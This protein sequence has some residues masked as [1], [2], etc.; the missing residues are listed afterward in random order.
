MT[1]VAESTLAVADWMRSRGF[2][3][4]EYQQRTW[5]ASLAGGSG[6]VHAPTGMGKTYAVWLGP[7]EQAIRDGELRAAGSQDAS[8][9]HASP[10]TDKPAPIRALWITPLRALAS[11]TRDNLARPVDDLG[12]N[13]S[14]E[15][16]TGDT[17]S[18][19]KARQRRR[20]PS[21]LVTTPESLTILLSYPDAHDKLK[22][23]RTVIVD[24]WHELLGTKRGTQT[25]LALAR[26]RRLVPGLRT[27]GLSATL[28]NLETARR[29]LVGAAPDRAD[30]HGPPS[31]VMIEGPPDKP[32]EL[33]VLLP[34]DIERFPWAGH[35]GTKLLPQVVEKIRAANSTLVFTNTRAQCEIWF[36]QINTFAPDLVGKVA[37]HHGSLDG[38]L[39]RKAEAMIRG[40]ELK[41]VVCTSS[42]DLGVD[43]AP[44]DQ[45]MQLGSPKGIARLLQRAG[46]SGHSPGRTSRVVCVASHALELV[47]FSAA[48]EALAAR[49]LEDRPP[50]ECPLDV[51][52]Q[53]MVTVAG[54]GGF[55]PDEL[56]E[57]V[58]TT[59]SYE[60]LTR[61][62]F[63]W[64]LRFVTT[65]GEALG[66]YPQYQRIKQQNGRFGPA[67][68][69][70][71]K[72]H[73]IAIGTITSDSALV[74]R[75]QSG[76]RLGTIEETFIARMKPG[77]VFAYA[78]RLLRLV[79]VRNM[80]AI[81][82]QAKGKK[83]VVPR[84]NGSRF[85]LSTQLADAVVERLAQAG[86]GE[87][88]DEAVAAV[89]PLLSLQQR[90]SKLPEPGRVLVELTTARTGR[91]AFLF[92]F[93]G[94]LVHEG[95]G[96][97]IAHRLT[98]EAPRTV[99]VNCNDY[100][101][102]LVSPETP[103][104]GEEAFWRRLL[105]TDQLTDD[106]LASVNTTV[107]ARRQFREIA[108]IA[109]LIQ[110]GYPGAGQQKSARHLQAS[111]EMF[112]DV[113]EQFDADNLL[114]HQ[115]RREV[116]DRQLEVARLRASLERIAGQPLDLIP[117]DRLTPLSFP[118]WADR[119]RAEHASSEQW[120]Q[121]L[122]RQIDQLE[123]AAEKGDRA[124]SVTADE[125][126]STR[127]GKTRTG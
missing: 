73:R 59:A 40:G 112:F 87:F 1:S 125:R 5:D 70:L 105:S 120:Q 21:A 106:L 124:E 6:L 60:A 82:T 9:P 86:R 107:M 83:G 48:R 69:Q 81:V 91:H 22:T 113:F 13:W 52:V 121:R 44:V 54:G 108:R 78:G 11:D 27:W 23:L 31:P 88:A 114:L 68:P 100:A 89:E 18:T 2:E 36:K 72:L 34:E 7:V 61:R 90:W 122:Q 101:L 55:A 80:E 93:Q 10:P 58:K 66:A 49:R 95:L 57:E 118:V 15:L 26:L 35:M 99:S 85:P 20:L 104:P 96:A 71:A 19:V 77:D 33:D 84:W 30:P 65:G 38:E 98:R 74:V 116:L 50:P 37:L 115:A 62:Q 75:Y 97:L 17:S 67:T 39:R 79:R 4:F 25:E 63:D 3:P 24:E 109:G 29:H 111:S 76:K 53:H 92:L 102:E 16:R 126:R 94:R 28:G 32:V 45:V 51:L 47:E 64:A 123:K 12:V 46:R 103:W 110:Q 8:A 56:F 42:L 41:A 43:F 117:T 127:W 119:L 14:V